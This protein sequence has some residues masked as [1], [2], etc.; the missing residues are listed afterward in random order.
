MPVNKQFASN[1]KRLMDKKK[2][3]PVDLA[4]ETGIKAQQISRYLAG[5]EPERETIERLAAPLNAGVEDFFE[6]DARGSLE[7]DKLSAIK[8]LLDASPKQIRSILTILNG[9]EIP[10][11]KQTKTGS[12]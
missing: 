8:L 2:F 10:A 1:L 12:G 7:I 4:R 9:Q 6:S 5:Q 3:R 11:R